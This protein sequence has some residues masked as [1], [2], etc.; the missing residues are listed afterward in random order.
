MSITPDIVKFS[1]RGNKP[2]IIIAI[3]PIHDIRKERWFAIDWEGVLKDE[4]E[5]EIF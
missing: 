3:E 2:F 1:H 5:N 4:E